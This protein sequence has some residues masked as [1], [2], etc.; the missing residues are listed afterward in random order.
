VSK[1]QRACVDC[2]RPTGSMANRCPAHKRA[3][4]L[5]RRTTDAERQQRRDARLAWVATQGLTC[6]GWQREA[7]K[8]DRF[9]D[10]VADHV[11]PISKGGRRGE[12]QALCRS[13]NARKYNKTPSEAPTFA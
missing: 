4:D 3:Y 7:H 9:E 5:R 6:P 12:L 2:G 1:G 11:I 10:L 13:C 8:V